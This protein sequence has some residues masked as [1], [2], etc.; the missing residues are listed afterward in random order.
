MPY[1]DQYARMRWSKMLKAFEENLVL[2]RGMTTGELNYFITSVIKAYLNY[3]SQDKWAGHSHENYRLY[4]EIMGVLSCITL[5]LY[6]RK[7][8]PYE[9]KKMQETGDVF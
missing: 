2:T 5:E 6:R 4:N 3:E 9:D 1:V 7:V 8:A